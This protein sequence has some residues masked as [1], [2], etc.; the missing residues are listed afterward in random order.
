MLLCLLAFLFF[1]VITVSFSPIINSVDYAP[2]VGF[3]SYLVFGFAY[4]NT[5]RSVNAKVPLKKTKRL[6]RLSITFTILLAVLS[7]VF[8]VL[9]NVL[10]LSIKN[11][12]VWLLRYS[13]ICAMPIL[14]PFVLMLAGV[15]NQPIESFLKRHYLTVA[16]ANI[17]KYDVIKI[18]ITGSY[19]KTSVKEILKTLLSQKFRVLSSPESYNTPLG[20]ALTV[21]NLDSTH[22]VLLLEMG[23]RHKGDIRELAE[24]VKPNMGVITGIN[25]QHLETF[26]TQQNILDTKFE[27]CEYIG[28][29]G[30]CFFS[31]D[32]CCTV[33]LFN[34]YNGDK[35][36]SGLASENNFVYATDISTDKR[37]TSFTLHIKGE[38][39]VKC[40]TVLLG[41][42]NV[43][44][45]C[46][47]VSVC[48]KLGMS[49]D[50]IAFGINRISSIGHRLELL[51]NN[52]DIVI[53]DDSYNS[54]EDGVESAI[55]VLSS[56]S[57]RKIVVTPGLIELGKR[58]NLANFK[59]GKLLATH[60][61][62]VIIVGKQNAEM[63]INGL[64]DGG[65]S[66]EDIYFEKNS[67]RG[68]ET[69]N[70]IIMKNDVVL[71]EN[72]L[73]DNYN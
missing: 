70:S 41:A 63:L 8:L 65:K 58:E 17:K 62:K 18:G 16:K 52:K 30:S 33:E 26:K 43:S 7:F 35:V 45:I 15:I 44:N 1:N 37:G 54:N 73:P 4:I 2:Y 24:M 19:G 50:E 23:A 34:K 5:E 59:F 46:L 14:L 61:D 36:L 28:T 10:G 71:F 40:L 6:V 32:S 39:P 72:D 20:V 38:Q 66:R 3:I 11:E 55:K 56:F 60:A 29:N 48:Y 25:S 49:V 51:P 47:A 67:S 12:M 31:S 21:K 9:L 64:L 13:L 68:N 22:D 42:H 69:L 53:I 27:L 57:G